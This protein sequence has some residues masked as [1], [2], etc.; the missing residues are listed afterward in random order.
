MTLAFAT[1]GVYEEVP[2]RRPPTPLPRTDVTGFVGF[3]RR[4]RDASDPSRLLGAPPVGHRFAIDV[5]PL[6]LRID[7]RE[8]EVAATRGHV[9]SE[10]TTS[11]PIAA[12]GSAAWTIVIA[13][14]GGEVSVASV[15]GAV[16]PDLR[17]REPDDDIIA[18]ALPPDATWMRIA[19]VHIRRSTAG[20]RVHLLV[21]P[22]PSPVRCD[23]WRDFE[24]ALGP[25]DALDTAVLGRAVRGFFAA[26]GARCHV[27]LVPRPAADDPEGLRRAAAEMVGVEGQRRVE[28][29][30]LESLLLIDEVSIVDAPDLYAQRVDPDPITKQLPPLDDASAFRRCDLP[31]PTTA[32]AFGELAAHAPLFDDGRV[33]EVQRAM[34]LRCARPHWRVVLLLTAPVDFD[35]WAGHFAAPTIERA[36]KWREDLRFVVDDLASSCAAFYFPWVLVQDDLGGTSRELPPGGAAAGVMAARDLSRGPHIAPANEPVSGIVGLS[37]PVDDDANARLYATPMHI[38]PLRP[39][40]GRGIR[41]WGARTMST[42]RWLRYLPVRRCLSAIQRKVAA[43]FETLV[44]EPNTPTLWLQM[45]QTVLSVL[46]PIFEAGA[47]R[48]SSPDEA[49]TITCDESNNPPDQVEIGRVVCDVGV[50]IA[51]PAEFI[52]FR[53]AKFER[54]VEIAEVT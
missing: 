4:V 24:S 8:A 41:V 10:S 16:V 28:A 52:V 3:E 40:P 12:G 19:G 43:A 11:I 45:T 22:G 44:F 37:R 36:M 13:R 32:Q 49:F 47:L 18:T 30:G 48:G 14:V 1:P 53:L 20:D 5:A 54:A 29:T 35:A 15:P 26:G 34:L 33:L 9:L 39:R 46:L 6:R 23:D 31:G 51:A 17:A 2:V 27:A 21:L 38:N 7:G 25:V 50:A 42:D